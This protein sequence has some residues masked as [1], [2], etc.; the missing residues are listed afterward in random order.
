MDGDCFA[1]RRIIFKLKNRTNIAHVSD[2]TVPHGKCRFG[3]IFR[4]THHGCRKAKGQVTESGSDSRLQ[5]RLRRSGAHLRGS[6]RNLAI[7]RHTLAIL[8]PR[9][10]QHTTQHTTHRAAH[11]AHTAQRERERKQ[12]SKKA[13]SKN[14]NSN[15]FV[16]LKRNRTRIKRETDQGFDH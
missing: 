15:T 1:A 16:C 13:N 3:P 7:Y 10:H 5:A 12:I 4:P 9:T 6:A 11:T 14:Q 8:T 2:E